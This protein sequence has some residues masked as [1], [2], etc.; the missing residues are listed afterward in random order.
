T[1][2]EVGRGT[3]QGLAISRSVIT[4]QHGGDIL[5]ESAPGRGTTFTVILPLSGVG[6]DG[7]REAAA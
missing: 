1:T 5:L 7:I 6:K 3:G 2:K 4:E